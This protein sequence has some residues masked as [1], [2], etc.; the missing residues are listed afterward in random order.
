MINISK[1][2]I[3]VVK[4]PFA[5]S[6]NYKARPAVVVSSESYNINT[7]DTLLIMAISSKIDNKLDF[8]FKIQDWKEAGLIKPSLLKSSI[9]TIEKDFVKT[10]LGT[11]SVN[12]IQSLEKMIK[13]IC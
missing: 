7:R 8:E 4:F 9:A 3:V 6:L 2:D 5:S 12:D 1:Y 13:I 11:L 10:K